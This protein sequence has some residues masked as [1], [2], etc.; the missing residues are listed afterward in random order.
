MKRPLACQSIWPLTLLAQ[1]LSVMISQLIKL[2][3]KELNG[4]RGIIWVRSNCMEK[5][6]DYKT[7]P[8]IFKLARYKDY[9]SHP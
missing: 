6:Q 9:K 8:H 2:V 5:M 3:F 1:V 4:G 7:Q